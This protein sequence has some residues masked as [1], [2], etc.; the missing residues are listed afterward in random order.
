MGLRLAGVGG[1]EGQRAVRELDDIP[2]GLSILDD[3]A[4]R[5]ALNAAVELDK[6]PVP[7]QLAVDPGLRPGGQPVQLFR[8]GPPPLRRRPAG[9]A[10]PQGRGRFH[11]GKDAHQIKDGYR[12][13]QGQKHKRGPAFLGSHHVT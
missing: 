13:R 8:H 1:D 9:G 3:P 7:V 6:Q 10:P 11:R 12:R 4:A 5:H 2:P